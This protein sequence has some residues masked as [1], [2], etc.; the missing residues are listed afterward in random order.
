MRVTGRQLTQNVFK[1]FDN[2]R[3]L[4]TV[5]QTSVGPYFK[6]TLSEI[7]FIIYNVVALCVFFI[8]LR[9]SQDKFQFVL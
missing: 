6:C 7:Y 4:L 9:L 3:D 1:I 5:K 8:N 2:T